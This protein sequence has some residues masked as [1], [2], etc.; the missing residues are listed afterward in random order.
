VD[1][2]ISPCGYG[3]MAVLLLVGKTVVKTVAG[4]KI[5]SAVAAAGQRL[6]EP[7]AMPSTPQLLLI[8]LPLEANVPR[9]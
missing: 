8:R 4:A 5:V 9:G 2:A 6:V 3:M 1:A 7:E